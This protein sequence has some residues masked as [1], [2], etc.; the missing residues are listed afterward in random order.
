MPQGWTPVPDPSGWTSAPASG[1][2]AGFA[3]EFWKRTN[4]LE[5]IK[6]L[7][8]AA[9]DVPGT[10]GALIKADPAFL[11]QAQEAAG[12]GDYATA[13]RKVLSYASMGL[14]HDL[15]TQA[16]MLQQGRYAEGA[17]AMAGTAANLAGPAVVGKVLGGARV[18][19]LAANRDAAV[20][21]AVETGRVA[22]VPMDAATASGNPFV[23]FA[24][25]TA[26]ESLLGSV[27]G[28]RAKAAQAAGMAQWGDELAGRAAP[29][30]VS[31]QQ[32]GAAA[33]A[34]GRGAVKAAR[35]AANDAYDR[36][37][38]IEA[39]P[40]HV[41]TFQPEIG[42]PA[43]D[44]PAFFTMK[45]KPTSQEVFLEALTDARQQGYK[46]PVGELKAKFDDRLAQARGLKAATLEGD[47]Y[48]HA[49]LLK[50]I[51]SRGGLRPYDREIVQGAPVIK[52]RGDFQASQQ[53]NAKNYGANAVYRNDGLALDD[54]IQQLSEDPKWGAVITQDTDLV[55]LLHKGAMKPS[56]MAPGDL[57]YHLKGVGVQP[58]VQWW[59]EGAAAQTVPMAVDLASVK[60]AMRPIHAR[61][62]EEAKLVPLMGPKATAYTKLDRLM[63]GPDVAPLSVADAALS[64]LKAMARSKN[65]DLRNAGQGI[66]AKA[67][68]ELHSM[69][70]QAAERAGPDAVAALTEG[71]QATIAKYAAADILKKLEGANRTK[72]PTLAFRGMTQ[73]G[74]TALEHLRD[75]VKQTPTAKP[76]IGRAVLDGLIDSPTMGPDAA[77]KAWQ[78]VGPETKRLLYAP[79]HVKALDDFFL[80]RKKIAE[81]P[82]PSGSGLTVLKGGELY[83]RDP[84]LTVG[85][86]VLSALLHSPAGVALL[87]RGFRLPGQSKV[88][89]AGYAAALAREAEK[90]GAPLAVPALAG[91]PRQ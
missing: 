77:F 17:G 81:N 84:G 19:A 66:A 26:D 87:T 48:S 72:S 41:S 35:G 6:G 73:A 23:K 88:A 79:D 67:V 56:A 40:E 30:A 85:L 33:Q 89:M 45:A 90:V 20:A 76:A 24:Q 49:A 65:P 86:P 22:G 91:E 52:A 63:N 80:L 55:D 83:M 1:G 18:P 9:G 68:G 75:V 15:D 82:N 46:G 37:R 36:L 27:V 42:I 8:T 54:M 58:G 70:A 7:V 31:P 38:A 11:T 39:L 44:A 5:A 16:E 28:Q 34:G 62:A 4:P 78:R 57:Q 3:R 32:A 2:A 71:R 13:L 69:V 29:T 12:K 14:G 21:R 25:K 64:D 50:E 60:D 59:N 61:L 51:R 43:A 53:A 47:E 74:D 10:I